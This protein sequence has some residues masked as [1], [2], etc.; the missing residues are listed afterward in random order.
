MFTKHSIVVLFFSILSFIIFIFF[1]LQ[2]SVADIYAAKVIPN[3]VET[4]NL[5]RELNPTN[6]LR[7]NNAKTHV[8]GRQ[9]D[10]SLLKTQLSPPNNGTNDYRL[11]DDPEYPERDVINAS[12][13]T[14]HVPAGKI[15]HVWNAKQLLHA[16]YGGYNAGRSGNLNV[17]PYQNA[18]QDLYQYDTDITKISLES[19]IDLT[20]FN[21][22]PDIS[23][24]DNS[25]KLVPISFSSAAF[26]DDPNNPSSTVGTA[27]TESYW[28]LT[29]KRR[30]SQEVINNKN[31]SRLVIDG[32]G[33]SLEL[34]TFS[35][36]NYH[37]AADDSNDNGRIN[38]D[39][40]A[41]NISI[42][43]N[44]WYGI[45]DTQDPSNSTI[46]TFNNVNYYG[47]QLAYTSGK[48]QTY[49]E[50]TNNVYSLS[51]Y[52]GLDGR[53]YNCQGG[54]TQQNLQT[55][56]IV[57]ESG[58]VYKG[59]TY[60]G[61]TIELTGNATFKDGSKVYLYPHGDTP[62]NSIGMAYGLYLNSSSSSDATVSLEGS[63]Q[64]FINCNNKGAAESIGDKNLDHIVGSGVKPKTDQPC[65]AVA[66]T[67]NKAR[68]LYYGQFGKYPKVNI[69]SDG[70]IFNNQPLVS[71][72]GGT[73]NLQ[74][75]EFSIQANNL[76]K[77]NTA[78]GSNGGG[79]LNV[80]SNMN[81][82][83]LT[84]GKFRLA[85]GPGHDSQSPLNL[86]YSK[87]QMNV[88]L[89]N[90]ADVTLDLSKDP[91]DTSALVYADGNS[92]VVQLPNDQSIGKFKIPK[93][94]NLVPPT[95]SSNSDIKVIDSK[96]RA[97]GNN[98]GDVGNEDSS[99]N[100]PKN[101]QEIVGPS[102]K[103]RD[104][105]LGYP[106]DGL[107]YPADY[108]DHGPVRIQQLEIP[109][110][111]NL[112]APLLYANNS[113]TV[114]AKDS[115]GLNPLKQ[116]M[117]AMLGK[118][119]RYINFSDLPGP[120]FDIAKDSRVLHPKSA[121]GS[122]EVNGQSGGDVWQGGN[123]ST[124]WDKSTSLIDELPHEKQHEEFV[125]SPPKIRVQLKRPKSNVTDPQ[126]SSDYDYYD[127]GTV[128]N[129]D[130]AQV[131]A[132][133]YIGS[134]V[135]HQ[136][137]VNSVTP[138]NLI[139]NYDNVD[140]DN[141]GGKVVNKYITDSTDK[142]PSYDEKIPHYL[143]S[144]DLTWDDAGWDTS[145][146]SNGDDI[147]VLH[148]K[149][150]YNLSDL[151]KKYNNNHP[152][153]SLHLNG[154]DEILTSVVTNF[155]SSTVASSYISNLTLGIDNKVHKFL[156]GDDISVPFH[157]YD[158]DNENLPEHPQISLMG[159]I[160]GD[161]TPISGVVDSKR[162]KGSA[163]WK[164]GVAK[165]SDVGKEHMLTFKAH[166]NAQPVNY[167]YDE[168]NDGD[169]TAN[170]DT[171]SWKYEV[172]NLPAYDGKTYLSQNVSENG[173]ILKGKNKLVTEF[174]PKSGAEKTQGNYIK[175]THNTTNVDT[176][177]NQDSNV[178][179]TIQAFYKDNMG[180]MISSKKV[181]FELGRIYKP[182]DF[183]WQEF[184]EGT[185]FKIVRDINV[186]AD[187]NSPV[188]ING[189]T[190]SDVNAGNVITPLG[191]SNELKYNSYGQIILTTPTMIDFGKHVTPFSGTIPINTMKKSLEINNDTG[192]TVK[193][194]KLTANLE[195]DE[196]FKNYLF[197]KGSKE[198][199]EL[200]LLNDLVLINNEEIG[201][202]KRY[203]S[204]NWLD[205]A[206]QKYVA[207]PTLKIPKSNPVTSSGKYSAT[208]NWTLT[209]GP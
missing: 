107:E 166:D 167:A 15:A 1:L 120:S 11:T 111:Q 25:G 158:S 137:Q 156:V 176:G 122:I 209:Y 19:D 161:A 37:T 21:S 57:F 112:I 160:D 69:T 35:F 81:I 30:P 104:V 128:E 204:D 54:G 138:N 148:H 97:R 49:M 86:L 93:G 175:I 200:P 72:L 71:F 44:S 43:G 177:W 165:D 191:Y 185:I 41:Q 32:N 159:N 26:A 184:H 197:Y 187:K 203:I 140:P 124:E 105:N 195:G 96:I 139:D 114:W 79:L 101:G 85:V 23:V 50:G 150:K 182:S 188:V 180:N 61:N 46:Q 5:L 201:S 17:I 34:G 131:K 194:I 186:T 151:I 78:N 133:S 39:L 36:L 40:V 132:D 84:G 95:G 154:N 123:V 100:F 178:N 52:I 172:V 87:S 202:G 117:F 60:N 77:Y 143:K 173:H 94:T 115:T 2:Y 6:Q 75:G 164:I 62:E 88:N 174:I 136:E 134:D 70:Q 10:F 29:I 141:L 103:P 53:T 147:D 205:E 193:N 145:L 82:N 68:F 116:A 121:D 118:E 110:T 144:S 74:K 16:A 127:L 181:K 169:K 99:K 58:C 63:S 48:V 80:G 170:G 98:I 157:Y 45:F 206:S 14:V 42:Y 135:S 207:G 51:S 27:A 183:G 106:D 108:L 168:N 64:L 90:P 24:Y 13:Q 198:I 189:D 119:F 146:N 59:Y 9:H 12:G 199:S 92:T 130:Q 3:Y 109:F 20:K 149:F 7:I 47:S 113:K 65:G 129:T 76:G 31:Y 18:S 192:N 208:I 125:P 102:D 190:I 38:Q 55:Q 33:H 8:F 155:Q 83:V 196:F 66:M 171:F 89:I 152:S 91:C 67:S 179:D 73:A 28:Y 162:G 142:D 4:E 22:D 163:S 56:H 126:L 153:A